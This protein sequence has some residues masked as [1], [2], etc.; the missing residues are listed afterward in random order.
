[1]QGDRRSEMK[2]MQVAIKSKDYKKISTL[3]LSMANRL[4]PNIEGLKK[5]YRKKAMLVDASFDIAK[6][7]KS[8]D[9]LNC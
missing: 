8:D 6:L 9:L 4:W 2:E 1:L 5:R 7:L 3:F